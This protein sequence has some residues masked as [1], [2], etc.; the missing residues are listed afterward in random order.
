MEQA[1]VYL[2]N[3]TIEKPPPDANPLPNRHRSL[4]QVYRH[5]KDAPSSLNL[6]YD[7][8]LLMD[9]PFPSHTGRIEMSFK[10][11]SCP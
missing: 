9:E 3:T 10:A 6:D 5:P 4:L 11:I 8:D 1:M 2:R 7:N